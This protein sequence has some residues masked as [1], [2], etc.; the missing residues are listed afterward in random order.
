MLKFMVLI[1]TKKFFFQKKEFKHIGVN[2]LWPRTTINT[3]PV[4]NLLGGD[5]MVNISRKTDVMGDAAK[6]IF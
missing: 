6:H 4:Q 2:T 3:A 5:A 1:L